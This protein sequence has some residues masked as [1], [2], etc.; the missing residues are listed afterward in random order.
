MAQQNNENQGGQKQSGQQGQ[1]GQGGQQSTR[2]NQRD[3]QNRYHALRPARSLVGQ[4]AGGFS[5]IS[6]GQAVSTRH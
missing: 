3:G 4:S 6:F 2:Q 5:P 1:R